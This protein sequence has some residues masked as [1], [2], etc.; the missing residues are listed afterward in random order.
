MNLKPDEQ[1]ALSL[2]DE[3][4]S[5]MQ[6]RTLARRLEWHHGEGSKNYDTSRAL[7][8]L[9]SLKRLGYVREVITGVGSRWGVATGS[10]SKEGRG[11]PTAQLP[12]TVLQVRGAGT[13]ICVT[14]EGC[15]GN[16][17]TIEGDVRTEF[18]SRLMEDYKVGDRLYAWPKG[19]IL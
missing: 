7:R 6:A 8:A 11:V 17:Y 12:A 13:K 10:D 1:A 2:L 5:T 19:M 15:E 14:V 4:G 16:K 9:K 3:K 18:G